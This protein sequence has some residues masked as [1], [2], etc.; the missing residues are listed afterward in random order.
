MFQKTTPE[1]KQEWASKI[2]QC[3]QSGMSAKA[4]CRKNQVVYPT[5]IAWRLLLQH[6]SE[7]NSLE[8]QNKTATNPLFVELKD[9]SKACS[10]IFL[11]C[12]GVQIHLAQEFD[13]VVLEKCLKVL[14]G[15]SC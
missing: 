1:I 8:N 10:G 2:K 14:R 7:P 11:E 9:T 6:H 4:W 3:R 15:S 5:F 13:S 12:E